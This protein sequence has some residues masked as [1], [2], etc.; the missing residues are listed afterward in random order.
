MLLSLKRAL[1]VTGAVAG[2]VLFDFGFAYLA[3]H[4][5]DSG[6]L[7]PEG[8]A[9]QVLPLVF[10]GINILVP[11]LLIYYRHKKRDR[12]I[13]EEADRWLAKRLAQRTR[14]SNVWFRKAGRALLWLPSLVALAV[15]LFEPEAMGIVSHLFVDRTVRL[16]NYSVPSSLTWFIERHDRLW[17]SVLTGKGIGRTGPSV[18]WRQGYPFSSFSF[19]AQLRPDDHLQLYGWE[20]VLSERKLAF[21]DETLTC[22]DIGYKPVPR[23]LDVA[24]I[25]CLASKNDFSAYFYGRRAD[26]PVFYEALQNVTRR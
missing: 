19:G 4:M 9:Q 15:V 17:L 5:Y 18:Y 6:V 1:R 13:E 26:T 3:A 12:W 25:R 24:E 16:G 7:A 20:T 8:F 11:I 2:L 22:W 10:L 23:D 21:G 14:P